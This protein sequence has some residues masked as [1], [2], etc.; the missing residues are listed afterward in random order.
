MRAGLP[1][2]PLHLTLKLDISDS[3]TAHLHAAME[4]MKP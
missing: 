1:H 2:E 3:A 4:K